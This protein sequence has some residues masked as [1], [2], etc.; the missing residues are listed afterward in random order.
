MSDKTKQKKN[1]KVAGKRIIQKYDLHKYLFYF[2]NYE[3]N[4]KKKN[5]DDDSNLI[6]NR[7]NV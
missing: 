1:C 4:K 5:D 6:K 7:K 3:F 2:I